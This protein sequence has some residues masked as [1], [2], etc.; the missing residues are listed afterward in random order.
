MFFKNIP[1][2]FEIW[3]NTYNKKKFIYSSIELLEEMLAR[4]TYRAGNF[5]L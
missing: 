4:D 1:A 5:K 2:Y 3:T